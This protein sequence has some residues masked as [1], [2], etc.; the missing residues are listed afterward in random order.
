MKLKINKDEFMNLLVKTQNIAEKKATMPVLINV[1]LKAEKNKLKIFA[2]DLE[3]SLTDKRESEVEVE[4]EIAVN[5][6]HLFEIIKELDE[7][8]ILLEVT[9]KTE[10]LP[11]RL[12][13]EQGKSVFNIVYI[14]ASKFP[15]FPT[16]KSDKFIELDKRVFMEM[17]DRTI[18]SVSNDETRYF[19]NGVFFEN[20][21]IS[22]KNHLRMVSTDGHRLSL[23]ERLAGV[24]NLKLGVIVPRKGLIEVRKIMD[25]SNE[26]VLVAIEGSQFVI[27]TE[28]TV[29]MIRLIEGKYPDYMRFIPEDIAGGKEKSILINRES[30]LSFIRRVSLLSNKKSKEITFTFSEGKMKITSNDPELGNAKEE[31]DVE[32]SGDQCEIGFNANYI[33][34]ILS[35]FS[36]EKFV[37]CFKNNSSPMI[38]RPEKDKDYTCVVMP[39]CL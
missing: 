31:L 30:F 22:E 35:S 37:L 5:T 18:Y 19:L 29:L 8:E 33:M 1:L 12:R 3:V 11:N 25:F 36:E 23:V 34:D 26:P 9:S 10:N 15:V 4:G 38:I 24:E 28:N 32:F 13:I 2:T 7:G 21:K 16:F 6:K 17:I 20:K 14:E 27:K 39:I